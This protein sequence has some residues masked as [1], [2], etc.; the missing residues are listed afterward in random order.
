MRSEQELVLG[1]RSRD[2]G[3]FEEFVRRYQRRVYFTA[4]RLLGGRDDALDVSQE[5]FLKM[6]RTAA[7]LKKDVILERWVY[8]VTVN[9]CIDRLRHRHRVEHRNV[10]D[11]LILLT[12]VERSMSPLENARMMEELNEVKSALDQL[13]ERQRTIFVLRHFQGL[14]LQEI[15]DVLEIPLGTV[16]ATLNQTLQKLRGLLGISVSSTQGSDGQSVTRRG[17]KG[18]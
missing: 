16:K 7:D 5:V 1:M 14:K 15:A 2:P 4:L 3:L 10:P 17:T 11:N 18:P 8:R 9:T 12:L 13:T 6:W